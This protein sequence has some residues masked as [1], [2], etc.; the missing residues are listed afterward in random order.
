MAANLILLTIGL[1]WLGAIVVWWIGDKHARLQNIFAVIFAVAAGIAAL[2]LI[3]FSS[4]ETALTLP[5][6]GVFGDFTFVADGLGVFLT[7]VATV[8]GSLA[9]IFSIEQFERPTRL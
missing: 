3:P 6:G 5:V 9:V 2:A 1:P 7:A 8:V 4:S